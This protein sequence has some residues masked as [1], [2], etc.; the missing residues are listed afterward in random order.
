M[1]LIWGIGWTI[2]KPALHS[3][4][5]VNFAAAARPWIICLRIIVLTLRLPE[6]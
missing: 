3:I 1:V 4:S 5:P 6:Q 2:T